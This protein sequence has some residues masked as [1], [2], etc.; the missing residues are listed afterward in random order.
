VGGLIGLGA[1]GEEGLEL[2][3]E[4]GRRPTAGLGVHQPL[5]LVSIGLAEAEAL[6]SVDGDAL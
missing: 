2:G 4:R 3:V 6:A 5:D 1:A